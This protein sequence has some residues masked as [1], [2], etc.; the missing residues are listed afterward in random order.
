MCNDAGY[1]KM[2]K[3]TLERTRMVFGWIHGT[4]ETFEGFCLLNHTRKISVGANMLDTIYSDFVHGVDTV[5]VHFT[6]LHNAI[7]CH[8]DG[9]WESSKFCHAS[10]YI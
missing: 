2:E 6:R 9:T 5:L 10:N 1:S 7:G 4:L 8:N 3:F